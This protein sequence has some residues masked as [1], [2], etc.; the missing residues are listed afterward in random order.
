MVIGQSS[1]VEH[2]PPA[3]PL[4]KGVGRGSVRIKLREDP[5]GSLGIFHTSDDPHPTTGGRID[6]P[7]R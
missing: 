2:P 4:V 6:V 7:G 5:T 3:E 1:R